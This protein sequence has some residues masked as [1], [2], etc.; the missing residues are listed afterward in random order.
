MRSTGEGLVKLVIGALAIWG[1]FLVPPPPEGETWAGV[2]PMGAAICL[3]LSGALMAWAGFNASAVEVGET[4]A[5]T[6]LGQ[7][8][9]KVLSLVILAVV[10]QQAIL[11]FGYELSTAIVGP[12]VLW[13]FGV[14]NKVG[15]VLS[16]ILFPLVFHL[17]FFKLLG[18]FPPI[19]EIFDLLDYLRG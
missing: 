1:A 12:I 15:V 14:R 8:S 5:S 9:I 2:L 11:K 18:V 7:I 10:Y 16:V 4:I 3:T 6:Q 19:G 13:L 17:L